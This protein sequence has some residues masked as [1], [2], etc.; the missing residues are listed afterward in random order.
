MCQRL[1]LFIAASM[2]LILSS[3]TFA[4]IELNDALG[5]KV[6]L[7]VPAQ[8]IVSLAPHITEVL[9]AAGAGDQVVGAVS[10]SDYPEQAKTIP[11]VGSYNSISYEAI[12]ALQPDLVVV[13]QS[14]NGGEVVQRLEALGLN[15]YVGEPR[16]L[17][18]IALS[19]RHM[20]LLS[21][22]EVTAELAADRF[23]EKLSKLRS[24][25]SQ[26]PTLGVFYQL[27]NEPMMTM[28]G[29]H[30]ISD[31]IR[32]C[33][34][35]NVFADALPFV[36][37]ISVES[38]VRANP[39]VIIASGSGKSRPKQLD[40]WRDWPTIDA[41]RNEQLYFIPPDLLQ[42]H[43]PRIMQGAEQMCTFL[44]QAREQIEGVGERNKGLATASTKVE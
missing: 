22:H 13:W 4:T 28:N 6:I 31:V 36:P 23:V 41:V 34:G 32:L 24:R 42:R 43:T 37:R 9:F 38:V 5:R 33:G 21:G 17:E 44:S 15:I 7:K 16:T 27:W 20:G 18:S 30:L 19:L 35:R 2:A 11:R 29:K 10:Y 40:D 26:Q 14:G 8:R 25:Y 3:A 1:V 39:Q 12:V